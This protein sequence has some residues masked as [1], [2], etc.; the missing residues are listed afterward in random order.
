MM[1]S[2]L[3]RLKRPLSL[4]WELVLALAVKA[5]LLYVI[6]ALWF[7][8]PIPSENGTASVTRAILNK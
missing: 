8:Q 1:Q 3:P 5:V 2:W 7:S 6:W 4:R